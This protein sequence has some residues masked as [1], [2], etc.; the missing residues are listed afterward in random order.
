MKFK[1][2]QEVVCIES[3][4]WPLGGRNPRVGDTV[5]ILKY[6][7]DGIYVFI[8]EFSDFIYHEDCF[9]ELPSMEE[10]NEALEVLKFN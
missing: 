1:S 9:E 10:I 4:N 2:G 6:A 3:S 7:T 5:T 8:S